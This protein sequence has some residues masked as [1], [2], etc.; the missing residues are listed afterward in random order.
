MPE[1][2][3]KH[4]LVVE[5]LPAADERLEKLLPELA[6]RFRVDAYAA[7]QRL[8]GHG[9]ALL[10]RGPEA[11]LA[12]AAALLAAYGFRS[13]VILPQPPRFTPRRLLGLALDEQG[14]T[15]RCEKQEVTLE[16]GETV[17]GVLAD[18]SSH[19]VD[20][21]LK[22]LMV[23]NAYRGAE[24]IVPLDGDELHQAILRGAPV[25]DAYILNADKEVRAAVRVFPGRFDPSGL[26]KKATYSAAGNLH[27]VVETVRERAGSFSLHTDFGLARLPGCQL[28]RAEDG[29]DSERENLL[30]LTRYGWLMVTLQK[31]AVA[32]AEPSSIRPATATAAATAT[33]AVAAP[34]VGAA[35]VTV[36]PSAAKSGKH[37]EG[38]R[39][40][41]PPADPGLPPP[42]ED[43]ETD[44]FP[45]RRVFLWAAALGVLIGLP[46]AGRAPAVG[47]LLYAGIASGAL[48]ALLAAGCF[49]AGFHY[50]SLR[51][52]VENTPTSRI[53]SL[54][55]GMVEVRGKAERLYAVVSPMSQMACVYYR[56]HRYRRDRNNS[57][58]LT[59]T[60]SSGAV[61]F[62]LQDETGRVTI[63]PRGAVVRPRTRQEGV[64]GDSMMFTSP[65]LGDNDEKWVEEVIAEGTSLYILGFA[66]P[67]RTPGTS[68]RERTVAV[69]RR[70]KSDPQALRR[71]DTNGDGEISAEEWEAARAAAEEEALAESLAEN[72]GT[73]GRQEKVVVGRPGTR[74]LPFIIAETASEARLTR[75]FALLGGPLLAAGGLLA[76]W[77]AVLCLHY[78][79]GI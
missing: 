23:Q 19:L 77:A 69:L 17:V 36:R 60:A 66:S 34:A 46:A 1:P 22:R 37:T 74:S 5:P 44:G 54:A 4:W 55:M 27:A 56:L 70:Y 14:I 18:L 20:K 76:V 16:Q 64:P 42:P 3:D 6:R 21:S 8:V 30:G 38:N 25:F 63:D 33:L 67:R 39:E 10:A 53:R 62:A 71:F 11:T 41:V 9:D 52:Q 40:Q 28:K 50:L 47:S 79:K 75:N 48:P 73:G 68:L 7:R 57:W 35:L 32:T 61:P 65:H 58:R 59:S 13:R 15:F 24:H 12:K 26:G 31:A 45:L 43:T 49:L 72:R 29:V 78:F 2:Q 51:Q